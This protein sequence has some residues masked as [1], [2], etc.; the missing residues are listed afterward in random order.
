MLKKTN[1]VIS[2]I[3]ISFLLFGGI[4]A[5][6]DLFREYFSKDEA[7]LNKELGSLSHKQLI[8]EIDSLAKSTE[9]TDHLNALIPFVTEL[10]QRKN[11]I[12]DSELLK[13]IKDNRYS[14]IT[15]ETLVDLYI[16][17][18]ENDENQ[19]EIKSLLLDRN[20]DKNIK[21]RIVSTANFST[22]DVELLK[23]L[24]ADDDGLLAFH[25][26]KVLNKLDIKMANQLAENI[27]SNISNASKYE[28]AAALKS[29]AAY[30]KNVKS[31]DKNFAYLEDQFIQLSLDLIKN[32]NDRYLQDSAFFALSEL[33]SKKAMKS[34]LESE[35]IDHELKVFAVDQNFMNLKHLL[36]NQPTIEDIELVIQAMGLL[37][38]TDLSEQLKNIASQ[39][40]DENLKQKIDETIKNIEQNGIKGNEKWLDKN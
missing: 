39:V 8:S 20:L 15:R 9:G 27:L 23:Q 11:E 30:L 5:A 38:I 14:L 12:D 36:N 2:I 3:C 24:I 1:I 21:A 40:T 13:D 26:M 28:L 4:V 32:S 10:F 25:S 29:R 22:G 19:E 7:T 35:F 17:K 18:H 31:I 33:G 16:V 37:P 34:I 6:N